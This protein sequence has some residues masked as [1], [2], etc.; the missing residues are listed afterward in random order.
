M[1]Q[2]ELWAARRSATVQYGT[3]CNYV[4]SWLTEKYELGVGGENYGTDALD[5]AGGKSAHIR[6]S[7]C[8]HTFGSHSIWV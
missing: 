3:V 8:F 2:S 7:A 5:I 1:L 4:S 6:S